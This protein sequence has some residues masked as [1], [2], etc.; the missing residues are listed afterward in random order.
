LEAKIV[1]KYKTPREA[2][3]VANAVSPDNLK[4]PQGLSV[5]TTR[6]GNKVVNKIQ[7]ETKLQTFM[8]TI[9]DLLSAVS[10]AER[11]LLVAKNEK[12][13]QNG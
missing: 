1:L 10:V 6:R 12:L 8:A 5:E 4:A 11:T 9:D 2:E 13:T 3:A 7:C